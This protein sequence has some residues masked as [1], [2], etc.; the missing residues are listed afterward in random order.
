MDVL[1]PCPTRW[2][3]MYDAGFWVLE[4]GDKLAQMYDALKLPKPK[5]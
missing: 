1:N 5:L 4:F 3:S 2:N